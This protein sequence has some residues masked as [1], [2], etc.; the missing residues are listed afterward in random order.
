[1]L[2]YS[3][4]GF[5]PPD[6]NRGIDPGFMHPYPWDPSTGNENPNLA[7]SSTVPTNWTDVVDANWDGPYLEKWP[8][9]HPW[10]DTFSGP[11]SGEV[12]DYENWP[13]PTGS[14]NFKGIAVS[15]KNLPLRVFNHLL[16][17]SA[18]GKFPF[19]LIDTSYGGN[20][21]VSAELMEFE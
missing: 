7:N 9:T 5:W 8:L 1:M 10:G 14:T 12:Y 19:T 2:Y 13:N 4:I 21:H 3:D 11:P 6:V 17:L 18:Q 20:H 15:L 16:A